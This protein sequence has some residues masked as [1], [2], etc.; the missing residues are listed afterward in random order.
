MKEEGNQ[1]RKEGSKR[2]E[3]KKRVQEFHK[4]KREKERE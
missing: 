3:N 1:V 4:C 2:R